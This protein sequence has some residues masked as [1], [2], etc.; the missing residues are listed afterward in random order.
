MTALTWTRE[1]THTQRAVVD[2]V[3][4]Q[5][6]VRR[7][8]TPAMWEVVDTRKSPWVVMQPRIATEAAAKSAAAR[9][10]ERGRK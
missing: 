5:L 2:G 8:G 3:S 7:Y 10:L 6:L 4:K 1:S 9:I